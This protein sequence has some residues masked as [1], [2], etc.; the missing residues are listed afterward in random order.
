MAP[1]SKHHTPHRGLVA[2]CG[3][4]HLTT[5]ICV[6]LCHPRPGLGLFPWLGTA[7]V[8]R[9]LLRV[10]CLVSDTHLHT[11]S[12]SNHF[13]I[14][15]SYKA[16]LEQDTSTSLCSEINLEKYLALVPP[17]GS[18][19]RTDLLLERQYPY[20]TFSLSSN[21]KKEKQKLAVS[22]KMSWEMQGFSCSSG[23]VG[24]VGGDSCCEVS[25]H[26]SQHQHHSVT[27]L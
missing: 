13:W 6:L 23:G 24:G 2:L 11:G 4:P 10:I 15:S 9:H 25:L 7:T 5:A 3:I 20:Y 14:R 22:F 12:L 18:W 21:V 17:R 16:V 19:F 26:F 8:C 1:C 27:H